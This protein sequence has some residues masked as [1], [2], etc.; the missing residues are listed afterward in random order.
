MD[1][2][3]H[4]LTKQVLIPIAVV[5]LV[6]LFICSLPMRSIERSDRHTRAEIK[7]AMNAAIRHFKSNDEFP[8]TLLHIRYD[9]AVSLKEEGTADNTIVFL[10]TF[11]TRSNSGPFEPNHLY[12]DFHYEMALRN[13]EWV[14]VSGGY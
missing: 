4:L 12:T 9:D 5:L 7:A 8:K 10:L 1:F 11:R 3:K 14:F 6:I 13:G 2:M